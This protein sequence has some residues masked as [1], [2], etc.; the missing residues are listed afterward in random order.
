MEKIL[1]AGKRLSSFLIFIH[2]NLAPASQSTQTENKSPVFVYVK[3]ATAKVSIKPVGQSDWCEIQKFGRLFPE[4]SL[5]IPEK[6]TVLFGDGSSAWKELTG[7]KAIAINKAQNKRTKFGRYIDYLYVKFFVERHGRTI[8]KAGVRSSDALLL[9]MRDTS[10]AY[11]MP[12]S[13]QWIKSAPWWTA[14]QVRITHNQESVLDTVVRGNA[15]VLNKNDRLCQRP[16]NYK[17]KVILSQG[18][19]LGTETDSCIIRLLS[20]SQSAIVKSKLDELKNLA[21]KKERREDYLALVD[22]YLHEK[23]Y[24]DMEDE[25]I[26]MIK[27]FPEDHEAQ[28][29]LYAYYASFL[30]EEVA[31]RWA[32]DRLKGVR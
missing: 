27:K 15:F 6:A 4:D 28:A 1:S 29:M 18:A 17:V 31:E 30:P 19:L 3:T 20:E 26:R 16:G 7:P 24:L 13:V 2:L 32:I 22:L 14:Y 11:T 21:E 10:V 23:L 8:T 9:A 25:L 5:K 12:E